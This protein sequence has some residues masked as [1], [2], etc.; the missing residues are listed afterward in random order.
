MKNNGRFNLK[1]VTRAFATLILVFCGLAFSNPS[2]ATEQLKVVP[3]DKVCMVT[4]MLFP[5][6]QIPVSHAGKT[7]YGCCENC[8]KTLSEDAASRMAVDPVSG[9]SV[10]K[11][12]AVIAAREDGTVVY[13]ESKKTFESYTGSSSS[14]KSKKKSSN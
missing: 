12:T 10:D 5:R 6:T 14:G 8:K 3:N 9:K 11:A 2:M 13:F 7:Y 4:N 1:S